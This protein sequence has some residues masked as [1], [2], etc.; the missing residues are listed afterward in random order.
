MCVNLGGI[1]LGGELGG[2]ELV[3]I[4][5]KS[6]PQPLASAIAEINANI[7]GATYE[8]LWYIG[9]Q[10][11]NGENHFFVCKEIRSTATKKPMIVGLVLNLPPG[12][13][14]T[15]GKGA[16]IVKVIESADLD[17]EA[18]CAFEKNVQQLMGVSYRPVAYAGK[19]IVRG[20]NHYII[21][22]AKTLYPGAEPYAVMI[23]LN[24]FK[25]DSSIVAIERI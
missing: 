1:T 12:E 24:I 14:V 17:E 16:H 11:V 4:S 20:V 9:K 3:N 21:C 8:P 10:L 7:L 5:A 22:E 2:Y 15:Q 23:I 19:Q 6:L 25:T 18:K 13:G